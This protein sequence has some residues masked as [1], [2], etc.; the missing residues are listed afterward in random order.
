MNPVG[1][2]NLATYD[3]GIAAI[4]NSQLALDW[5]SLAYSPNSQTTLSAFPPQQQPQPPP[6]APRGQLTRKQAVS[7]LVRSVRPYSAREV[8]APCFRIATHFIL[9]KT[10]GKLFVPTEL[11]L[12]HLTTEPCA[13]ARFVL[14]L[15]HGSIVEV[16]RY[17]AT[18]ALLCV[19]HAKRR[20]EFLT[21][22]P[23]HFSRVEISYQPDASAG[24]CPTTAG[25]QLTSVASTSAAPISASISVQSSSHLSPLFEQ[26][27][28]T[29]RAALIQSS[30]HHFCV[31]YSSIFPT[32]ALA[33]TVT[34]EP[35]SVSAV[36]KKE[37]IVTSINDAYALTF[38]DPTSPLG[39]GLFR[40]QAPRR[41]LPRPTQ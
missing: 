41:L 24:A 6:P 22:P 15:Q 11:G 4:S 10:L 17:A 19:A 14:D 18:K 27:E 1:S 5:L 28:E 25:D 36:V 13:D 2:L 32:G 7:S 29:S 16:R 23:L 40:R 8:F 26:V 21:L 33:A 35:G 12:P 30:W 31:N 9:G 20:T 38:S 34:T 3:E 39:T 37:I